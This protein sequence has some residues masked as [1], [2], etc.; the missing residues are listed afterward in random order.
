MRYPSCV[1]LTELNASFKYEWT[2]QGFV[3]PHFS[4]RKRYPLAVGALLLRKSPRLSSTLAETLAISLAKTLAVKSAHKKHPRN[5][6]V[7]HLLVR[8]VPHLLKMMFNL[9]GC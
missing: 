1:C 9:A 4:S 7:S 8:D 3:S 2:D 5:K 6:N